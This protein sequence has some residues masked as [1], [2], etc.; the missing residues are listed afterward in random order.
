L[1]AFRLEWFFPSSVRG[2]VDFRLLARFA[3]TNALLTF[4][5]M[6]ATPYPLRLGFAA[7]WHINRLSPFI[8]T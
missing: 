2:P 4:F 6:R 1:A 3:A 8:R 7:D 5:P